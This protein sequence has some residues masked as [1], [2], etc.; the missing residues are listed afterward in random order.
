L[1]AALGGS[2]SASNP[3]RMLAASDGESST[4]RPPP[5]GSNERGRLTASSLEPA[6]ERMPAVLNVCGAM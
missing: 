6:A 3:L 1:L 2:S 5:D 4:V